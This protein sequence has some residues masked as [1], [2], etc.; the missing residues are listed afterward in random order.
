MSKTYLHPSQRSLKTD[1]IGPSGH[2]NQYHIAV[3]EG[4]WLEERRGFGPQ[5]T[6]KDV[7]STTTQRVSYTDVDS[8]SRRDAKPMEAI[9]FEA[10]R[11]LLFFHGPGHIQSQY[12][13]TEL[14]YRGAA[15]PALT[16]KEVLG[17]EGVSPRRT[18][19]NAKKSEANC[20]E[21]T[22]AN[23]TDGTLTD[24]GGVDASEYASTAA[25]TNSG[26]T[27]KYHLPPIGAALTRDRFTTS[28]HVT[29]DA[30]GAFLQQNLKDVYNR[31]GNGAS[32]GEFLTS[33]NNA[34]HKTHLRY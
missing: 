28:K 29:I 31:T 34:M 15:A 32:R 24:I 6:P 7:L 26:A 20:G 14:S 27:S 5:P 2:K 33:L 23:V 16:Y 18:R 12:S 13:V 17:A 11:E 4:N 1:Q 21:E 22:S 25:A 10:P 8:Q 19:S 3:L 30:T 9:S